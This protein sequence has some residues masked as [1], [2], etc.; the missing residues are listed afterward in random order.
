MGVIEGGVAVQNL[1]GLINNNLIGVKGGCISICGWYSQTNSVLMCEVL[2][3]LVCLL[4][5]HCGL[6]IW[7]RG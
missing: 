3:F 1:E 4:G 2:S 7:V 5:I 6:Y